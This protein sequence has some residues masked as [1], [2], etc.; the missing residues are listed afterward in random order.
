MKYTGVLQG[1]IFAL[2]F[3]ILCLDY[4]LRKSIDLI[5]RKWF[6]LKKKRQEADNI[7]QKARSG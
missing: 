4:I 3:F 2:Y 5:N 6:L 1:D 7:Q